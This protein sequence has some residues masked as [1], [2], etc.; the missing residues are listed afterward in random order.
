MKIALQTLM[1]AGLALSLAACG[2]GGF[3]QPAYS[4][5]YATGGGNPMMGGGG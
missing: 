4:T 3:A 2:G 5:G 1:A